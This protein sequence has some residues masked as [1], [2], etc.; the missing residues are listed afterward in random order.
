MNRSNLPRRL[1]AQRGSYKAQTRWHTRHTPSATPWHVRTSIFTNKITGLVGGDSPMGAGIANTRATIAI[2]KHATTRQGGAGGDYDPRDLS[3][4]HMD[5][6]AGVGVDTSKREVQ[7][8]K[9]PNRVRPLKVYTTNKFP[10]IPILAPP[11]PFYAV[12]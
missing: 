6:D 12:M 9:M 5:G 3:A 4:S 8:R 2:G 1:L 10:T 7:Y 11:L